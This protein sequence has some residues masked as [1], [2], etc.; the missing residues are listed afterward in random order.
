M[1]GGVDERAELLSLLK[2]LIDDFEKQLA[3]GSMREQVLQL[4]DA[5]HVFRSVGIS[6][7][8]D[9]S[10]ASARDRILAYLRQ[11][12][13]QVIG[14]DELMIISGIQE[15]ARRV[16][17][18]RT[19][20]G[21]PII[22]GVTARTMLEGGELPG[23]E[24]ADLRPDRYILLA[25]V[26]DKESAYRYS[27]MKELRSDKKRS[28]K[29]A[30]LQFLRLNVGKPVTGEELSYVAKGQRNWQRRLRELRTEQGWPIMTK[31]TGRPDLPSGYYLLSA[32]RQDKVHD[33]Q[34][35]TEVRIKVLDR[36]GGKCVKCGWPEQR[37]AQ[38]TLRNCLELHH[39]T[40]HAK[41][42]EN[43][44]ENLVTLCNVHHDAI[45]RLDKHNEW[46]VAE[47]AAWIHE[48]S[49]DAWVGR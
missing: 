43:T 4:V 46:T 24:T 1:P 18:L 16:R 13:G 44:L 26:Q 15:Y 7:S 39:V 20:F 6:L 49:D 36:D 28:P 22:S 34:I 31:N 9:Y 37:S 14:G 23:Y 45:H 47:V 5:L 30:M 29:Q 3:T 19:E 27:L 2:Q 42:G 40:H 32:D 8:E 10:K 41:G 25:D 21:W 35:S 48:T 11:Y 17:E 12:K 33:R 38:D